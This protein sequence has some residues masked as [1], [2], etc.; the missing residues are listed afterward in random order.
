MTAS[1]VL[2]K[3][4]EEK[5]KIN[6]ITRQWIIKAM[7]EYRY[8]NL[9]IDD[10]RVLMEDIF[11]QWVDD[12]MKD[13]AYPNNILIPVRIDDIKKSELKRYTDHIDKVYR[14]VNSKQINDLF[15]NYE[16]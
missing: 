14:E 15:G 8:S 16:G 4:E 3:Y 11:K 10:Y 1:E 6:N 13:G 5:G 12:E 7:E 2:G 9:P